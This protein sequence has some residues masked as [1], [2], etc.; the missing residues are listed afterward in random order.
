[1]IFTITHQPSTFILEPST[2]SKMSGSRK[3]APGSNS[4]AQSSEQGSTTKTGPIVPKQAGP[5]TNRSKYEDKRLPPTPKAS[6]SSSR[7]TGSEHPPSI[8]PVTPIVRLP[9]DHHDPKDRKITDP[10]LSRPLLHPKTTLTDTP[11]VSDPDSRKGVRGEEIPLK[12]QPLRLPHTGSEV[13]CAYPVADNNQ[14]ERSTSAP[15]QTNNTRNPFPLPCWDESI[16]PL[17]HPDH[18]Q[19]TNF[20]TPPSTYA[21][22]ANPHMGDADSTAAQGRQRGGMIMGDGILNP[23]RSGGYGRVGR[24]RI[25]D[26]DDSQRVTS[27]IGVIETVESVEAS[28]AP[29]HPSH[30]ERTFSNLNETQPTF[31]AHQPQPSSSSVYTE[32]NYGGVWENHP[33]V[34]STHIYKV[35][36]VLL[37][38]NR[39]NHSHLSR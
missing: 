34:V 33:H 19:A 26:Q 20:L 7:N 31:G 35:Y 5:P 1:M 18:L 32:S 29:S 3:P 28:N 27:H 17:M 2:K 9:P 36:W 15:I 39:A 13:T 23:S 30:L 4:W 16:S 14:G 21:A 10:I 38:S 22:L 12:N 24:A 25:V 11:E 6:S 37:T 8:V